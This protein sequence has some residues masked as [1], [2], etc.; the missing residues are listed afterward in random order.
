VIPSP[1]RATI[2]AVV[3]LAM[4]GG[5][6]KRVPASAQDPESAANAFFA[7]LEHGDPHAAYDGAAF[8]FQAAQTYAAFISNA[9]DLGLIG[10]QAPTW[11]S[12]DVHDTETRLD[13]TVTNQSGT[14]I[15]LSVTMTPDGTAWKLFSLQTSALGANAEPE[16]RFTLVGKGTGFNDVYHQPMPGQTELDNLVH[17]TMAQLNEAVVS[18]DFHAFYTGISQQWKSGKRLTGQNLGGVTESILKDHFQGFIDK[19]IDLSAVAGL[20]PVY[21]QNPHIDEDGMLDVQGHFNAPQSRVEFAF[22]YAYELPSWKLVSIEVGIR[23]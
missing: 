18:Q 12:K 3:C 2:A 6:C 8:G 22:E 16:N 10:G 14:P 15:K 1:R 20:P 7:A 5:A 19:K 4:M 9:Q 13:G 11:T 21:D 17:K 23:Q